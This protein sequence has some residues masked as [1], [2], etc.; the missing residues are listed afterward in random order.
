MLYNEP[1]PEHPLSAYIC[2]TILTNTPSLYSHIV[3]TSYIH[4]HV[5]IPE[6]VC[7]V[8]GMEKGY[9][10]RDVTGA[11]PA[12]VRWWQG[13]GAILDVTNPEAVTW[14]TQRL[15]RLRDTTGI[16]SYKFD[17]GE[18]NF[19]PPVETSQTYT[20]MTNGN[21]YNTEYAQVVASFGNMVEM[22]SGYRVQ[23]HPFFMRMLDKDSRWGWDNGL[24]TMVTTALQM[25]I[26]GYP[27]ILPDMIGGNGYVD[28]N[29]DESLLSTVLPDKELFIRW[30]ELNAYLPAMQ[31]SISPWQYDKETTD[32]SKKYTS[33]HEEVVSP[34]VLL[35]A[36][37][38]VKT[39]RE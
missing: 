15:Q 1:E 34:I 37:D 4:V 29:M 18:I 7:L 20:P 16:D 28:G 30:V 32:I 5:C 9:W 23:R 3:I 25:G 8:K 36:R 24:K 33:M 2:L 17:G 11:V 27:F 13:I 35:A 22:R 14:Y 10:I 26:A 31:F 38:S 12:L 21:D 6:S 19:L 39:G